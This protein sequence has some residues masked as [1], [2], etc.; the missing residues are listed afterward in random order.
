MDAESSTLTKG[1]RTEID[2]SA[3]VSDG[4]RLWGSIPREVLASGKAPL[5]IGDGGGRGPEPTPREEDTARANGVGVRGIVEDDVRGHDRR[6]V[7]GG[8]VGGLPEDKIALRDVWVR[9]GQE[10]HEGLI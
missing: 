8:R 7:G 4:E 3:A 9:Q 10:G 5:G 6:V 2:A 1:R